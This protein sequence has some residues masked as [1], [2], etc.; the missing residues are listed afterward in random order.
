MIH[1]EHN[2]N[3]IKYLVGTK[4]Y[5]KTIPNVSA[6]VLFDENIISL[7]S[8][9]SDLLLKHPLIR[10]YQDVA[11]FAFWI[12]RNSLLSFSE[13][14]KNDVNRLGRGV[15]FQI[16]PSN[17]PIQ[18]AVTLVYALLSGNASVIRVSNKLFVQVDIL[19]ETLNSL[20]E[21][22]YMELKQYIII[23]RYDYSNMITKWL[24]GEC[25]VRIIWG[26]NQT[27]EAIRKYDIGK[28]TL[29]LTFA[30][31]FSIAVINSDEYV[32]LDPNRIAQKFYMDTYYV[33][34]NACSSPRIVV[35]LGN[36]LEEAK[37][38]FW[39]SLLNIVNEQY[40]FQPICSTDKLLQFCLLA[41]EK[42]GVNMISD[43]NKIVRI[44]IENL[45]S[46][47]MKYKGNSG[48]FFEYDA[49]N[50]KEILKLLTKECQTITCLGIDR[51]KLNNLIKEN[52]VR[53][54]D[55]IVDIGH[56]LD[57]SLIW[58]GYDMIREL[59]RIIQL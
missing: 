23:I 22:K 19:C 33:D 39:T 48:F 32:K 15:V 27:I 59:S 40:D 1:M 38:T 3:E 42:E 5:L 30:D 29:E 21:E 8:D 54:G 14:Y 2:F 45:D 25:D 51:V 4:D 44:R 47:I 43:N 28:R 55:R 17:I 12:R 7:L 49:E 11:A 56:A 20:L 16:A 13:Y 34:Q 58:D 57:L 9:W 18:F 53:G 35:W 52:G 24:S 41:S 37:R 50:L 10:Q 31:R 36:H 26:G 6:K 46:E